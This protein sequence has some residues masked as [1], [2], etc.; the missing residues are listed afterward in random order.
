MTNQQGNQS[1][2]KLTRMRR[3]SFE[4]ARLTGYLTPQAEKLLFTPVPK[5]LQLAAA[6]REKFI[7]EYQVNFYNC[8]LLMPEKLLL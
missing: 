8:T 5:G 7:R 6:Q 2:E 4:T 1:V 3:V